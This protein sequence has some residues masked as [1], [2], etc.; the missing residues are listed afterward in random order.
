M[1]DDSLSDLFTRIRNAHLVGHLTVLVP[2][3]STNKSILDIL[4][5]HGFIQNFDQIQNQQFLVT[6]KSKSV[7]R[8]LQ[9]LSRPGCRIYVSAQNIP[10]IRGQLGI[11]FL[12]TSK[13]ILSDREARYLKLGGEILGYIS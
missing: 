1:N 13:G 5:R 6:F 9:R 10:Q 7:I 11:L 3:S 12:S 4:V 8:E 2:F